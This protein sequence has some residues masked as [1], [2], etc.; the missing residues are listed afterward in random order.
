[1]RKNNLYLIYQKWS[2]TF[3]IYVQ[4][5]RFDVCMRFA[6]VNDRRVRGWLKN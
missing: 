4:I 3:Q 2:D 5:L 6:D 1:M